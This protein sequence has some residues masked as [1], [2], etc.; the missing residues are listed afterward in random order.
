MEV[1]EFPSNEES[2]RDLNLLRA[3]LKKHGR[4]VNEVPAIFINGEEKTIHESK[5]VVLKMNY[6]SKTIAENI[7][8]T[9]IDFFRDANTNVE[10]GMKSF[11]SI[12]SMHAK[13]NDQVLS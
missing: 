5:I 6:T 12:Y 7:E 11:K 13:L 3:G 8:A 4:Y 9:L 10:C 1:T 2:Q